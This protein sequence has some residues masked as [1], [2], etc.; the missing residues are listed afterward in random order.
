MLAF[1]V[2]NMAQTAA[3]NWVTFIYQGSNSFVVGEEL[4]MPFSQ[5]HLQI[6]GPNKLWN[7]FCISVL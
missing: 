7:K 1:A 6:S 4:G 2:G 3:L 5:P